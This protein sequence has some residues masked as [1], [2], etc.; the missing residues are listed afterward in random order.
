[1][2]RDPDLQPNLHA[3]VRSLD[4]PGECVLEVS[5]GMEHGPLLRQRIEY[6]LHFDRTC[7]LA[8]GRFLR[9]QA[10]GWELS[11]PRS[12]RG[13]IPWGDEAVISHTAA[14]SPRRCRAGGVWRVCLF[15]FYEGC[16]ERERGI[17]PDPSRDA[18]ATPGSRIIRGVAR[19]R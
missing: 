13:H 9:L 18:A 10:M 3:W 15:R 16:S 5:L 4:L 8:H 19:R 14:G 17:P 1:M 2:R 6:R 12:D 7:D 11:E